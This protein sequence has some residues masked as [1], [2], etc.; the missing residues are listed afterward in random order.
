[1]L[2]ILVLCLMVVVYL[3]LF[4]P[5]VATDPTSALE[6]FCPLLLILVWS[7]LWM[8]L[9]LSLLHFA[10]ACV[11]GSFGIQCLD[12]LLFGGILLMLCCQECNFFM[13]IPL[14][15]ILCISL[16][17]AFQISPDVLFFIGSMRNLLWV[18]WGMVFQSLQEW[19]HRAFLLLLRIFH[20]QWLFLHVFPHSCF[21]QW[22]CLWLVWCH[23]ITQ[24]LLM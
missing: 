12:F 11:G 20:I 14:W 18:P 19:V 22:L 5:V 23:H 21:C 7:G 9:L 10:N 15:F 6:I 2:K 13:I 4:L 8:Y 17:Y 1:M 3:K 24:D 16:L